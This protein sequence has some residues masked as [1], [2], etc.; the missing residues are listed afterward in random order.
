MQSN[1]WHHVALV[2]DADGALGANGLFGY[3]DGV[4]FGSGD[5][6]EIQKHLGNTSLGFNDQTTRFHTGDSDLGVDGGAPF[7]GL[8]DDVLIFNRA[9]SA[10]EVQTLT[11]DDD[12]SCGYDGGAE[13]DPCEPVPTITTAFTPTAVEGEYTLDVTLTNFT[14]NPNGVDGPS[15]SNEGHM[16]LLIDGVKVERFFDLTHTVTV[17]MGQHLVE[18]ELATND[19]QP[20]TINGQPIRSGRN[21]I[22]R[23]S[24]RR[25]S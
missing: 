6:A 14:L 7:A 1:T 23:E 22:R 4:L 19:H 17:P 15:S 12:A 9:L 11:G 3:L 13:V 8:I 21:T 25:R 2:L 24:W 5:G 16:H 10:T 20:W 18:V